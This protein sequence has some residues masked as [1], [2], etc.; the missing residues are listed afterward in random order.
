[1][2]KVKIF[3]AYIIVLILIAMT[4]LLPAQI[5][6]FEFRQFSRIGPPELQGA[7]GAVPAQELNLNLKPIPRRAIEKAV[8]DFFNAWNAGSV[9]TLLAPEFVDAS[10][11][12][13]A[14]ADTVPRDAKIRVQ[15]IRSTT[16]LPGDLIEELPDGNGFD[17]IVTVSATVDTVIE[18]T[19]DTGFQRI[20]GVSD[21]LF[22]VREEYR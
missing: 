22:K 9:T 13:D 11:L 5:E 7:P 16:T 17:R 8:R 19:D 21:Y 3:K 18:F 12:L 14:I 2:M 6:A 10:R 20:N 1:M 4:V 15:S